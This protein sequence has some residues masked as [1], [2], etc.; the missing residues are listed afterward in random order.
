VLEF[1]NNIWGLGPRRIRVVVPA[2]QATLDAGID[3]KESIPELHGS[4]KIPAL[5]TVV[6]K[7]IYSGV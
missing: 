6:G 4:L 7:G 5:V 3:S 2:R 1:F